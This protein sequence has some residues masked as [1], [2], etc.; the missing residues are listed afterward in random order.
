MPPSPFRV[1]K[2]LAGMRYPASKANAL[3][4][5][6]QRGADEPILQALAVL[7]EA[8][9]PSPV[10]LSCAIARELERR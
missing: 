8:D 7:P 10:A 3:E 2:Y 6:R 4:R 1:Q 5:A 9:Y